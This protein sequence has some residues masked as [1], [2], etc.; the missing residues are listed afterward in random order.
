MT[1]RREAGG[2]M[3]F[4]A[5][6][7]VTSTPV[8]LLPADPDQV[9]VSAEDLLIAT[10]YLAQ[11]AK[12]GR[13]RSWTAQKAF[14]NPEDGRFFVLDPAGPWTRWSNETDFHKEDPTD[15]MTV[16]EGYEGHR[17]TLR[18]Y[19]LVIGG[20]VDAAFFK[21]IFRTAR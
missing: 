6:F 21:S 16:R 9:V 11:L 8:N 7:T 3:D 15:G 10:S 17:G 1:P 12:E 14:T 13:I 4:F 20:H 19:R 18:H 2:M 5:I